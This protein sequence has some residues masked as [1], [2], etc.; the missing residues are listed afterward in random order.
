MPSGVLPHAE[1]RLASCRAA[2]CLMPSGVL[3]HAERRLASPS[4]VITAGCNRTF[5]VVAGAIWAE[6]A[7]AKYWG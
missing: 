3:P 5:V 2:S 7:W 4:R 6:S 1:R